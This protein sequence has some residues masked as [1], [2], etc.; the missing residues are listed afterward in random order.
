MIFLTV[1]EGKENFDEFRKYLR[2]NE[3]SAF[4]NNYSND[5]WSFEFNRDYQNGQNNDD[6]VSLTFVRYGRQYGS[7]SEIETYEW[8][9]L[10]DYAKKYENDR[11]SGTRSLI[12]GINR[13]YF[14]P[15]VMELVFEFTANANTMIERQIRRM[16]SIQDDVEETM[17]GELYADGYIATSQIGDF[18]L[19]HRLKGAVNNL[20]MGKAASQ[21]LDQWL[22]DINKARTPQE[23]KKI[24]TWQN[25][26]INEK[27]K[28]AVEKIL[29]VPD[30]CLIQGPPG[31]GKTSRALRRMV[32]HFYAASSMQILLLAYTN[33]AVDEICQSL[34]SITPCIDYIRVGSELSCDVRFR[35][36]LLENILA[37]CNSRREVNIRMADCRVYVGTVA[38]IAAK[39]ELFKLKRF[40]VAIVDEATQILEPQLL[41]ILC[42]KFADERNAVGKFILIGDHKQLPAV[43]LQNSG[44]SEVHDEGLREAGLFNLKDSLFER[45]YRFHL[46]EESPKAIDM[47]CRQGRMHPG[48][49]F[50][51]NKAFYAGKLEALGL[52]HQL[53][54]IE[55]PVRFIPS[56][57]DLESVSGKTNRYEAQIVAGLA[58]EV[59]LAHEEEFDP[60]RTLGVITPYRSQIALIRKELQALAI[61]A[62]SRISIDT[63]ERYQGSERDV[64][65][66]SFCVNHLYQLR[67]LP[68]LTEEDG[69]QIDRKLNVAL[70]RARKQLF[71]TGV[72]EILSHNSIYQYL[73]KTIY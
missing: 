49:A 40:D 19:L 54:H 35:G 39:A 8:D 29:S 1:A 47:L 73:L 25:S 68:N 16:G 22:F 5:R 71:I 28:E 13:N 64:I 24:S 44:H 3:V 11:D 53:E 58:K 43:I 51:P 56:K 20:V 34:S 26:D 69:V 67:F 61:P 65:I 41:G 6:G 33:R 15:Y 66:Y 14:E 59:Y 38:S 52:P 7:L 12:S 42:A 48:V 27:Q 23:I 37:E 31:T 62:L 63:V 45:L 36:H 30:V 2:R 50:F 72:P 70:T 46:K 32:E 18:A 9:T 55:A 10:K 60:N 17:A 4:S 21:G 57:Q